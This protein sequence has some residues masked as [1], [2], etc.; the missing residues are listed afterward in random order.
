M[1]ADSSASIARRSSTS[2]KCARFDGKE[3]KS[4]CCCKAAREFLL[5][6]DGPI[7]LQS[8]SG[9][10]LAASIRPIADSS[11]VAESWER[12]IFNGGSNHDF[13]DHPARNHVPGA[14]AGS[15][16][17]GPCGDPRPHREYLQGVH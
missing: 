13:S 6:V 14:G 1:H 4:S 5:V 7:K 3:E 2:M 16:L 9:A 11:L 15:S 8:C 17:G 12:R 10:P